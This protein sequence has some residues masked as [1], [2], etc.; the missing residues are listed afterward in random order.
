MCCGIVHVERV[1]GRPRQV[2]ASCAVNTPP[3]EISN[4]HIVFRAREE[5][6]PQLVDQLDFFSALQMIVACVA[7]D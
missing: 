5:L 1:K 4:A 2:E 6:L 3:R 7:R